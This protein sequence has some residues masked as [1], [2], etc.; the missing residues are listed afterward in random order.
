M[1]T[2]MVDLKTKLDKSKDNLEEKIKDK[3]RIIEEIGGNNIKLLNKMKEKDEK[4][5]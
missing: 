5:I 2:E 3:D 1:N 4:S